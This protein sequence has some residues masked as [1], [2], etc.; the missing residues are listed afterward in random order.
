MRLTLLFILLFFNGFAQESSSSKIIP[1][2]TIE[3]DSNS[4]FMYCSTM[5]MMW[6][7]LSNYLGEK[8]SSSERNKTI[9]LLNES[10]SKNYQTPIE[11]EFVVIQTGLVKDDIV[12]KINT[13]LKQKFND[14]WTPP[15]SMSD[16][17][18]VSYAHLKKEVKFH[19]LLDDHFYNQPFNNNVHVDYFGIK[20]GDPNRNRKGILIYD[21]KNSDDFI[22]QIKCKDSLDEIYFAKIPF[23]STLLNSYQKV[24]DRLKVEN[25]EVFNGGDILKIPYIK[26]DTTMHY[27]EL[28]Q[29]SLSN[30]LLNNKMFQNVSQRISFDLNPQGIKLE[31]IVES[32]IDFAD[33]E[34][35]PPRIL[36]FDKPFLIIMKRKNSDQP[37]FMY[38]VSGTEFMKTYTLKPRAIEAHENI[39]VGKWF[40]T[41]KILWNGTKENIYHQGEN[42]VF[43]PDGTFEFS[44]NGHKS[45]EGTWKYNNKIISINWLDSFFGSD[46]ETDWIL[47][48]ISERKFVIGGN[49]KLTFEKEL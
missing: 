28:E 22:V 41:E 34:N 19:Y 18:L 46:F 10:I 8:P 2:P 31:S 38:R 15:L 32:I 49:T 30:E 43:R 14:S 33:F 26:F 20:E 11:E 36:A 13:E 35:P 25:M 23:E 44:P 7:D 3:L 1:V 5:E 37:Y 47:D 39:V 48:E 42:Y 45:R 9:E 27:S 29:S 4:S 16:D 12:S 21:Y 24:L 40:L 17:A 6:N